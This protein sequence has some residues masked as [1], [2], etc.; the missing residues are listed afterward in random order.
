MRLAE[1]YSKGKG[2]KRDFI[3]AYMWIAV[4]GSLGDPDALEKLQSLSAKMKK[5]DL[6]EAQARARGWIEQHPRDPEDD[7]AESIQYRP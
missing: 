1:L 4:A 6:L 2:V 5:G 7:P 3:E